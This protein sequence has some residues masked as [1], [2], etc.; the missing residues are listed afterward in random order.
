M[1]FL[2]KFANLMHIDKPFYTLILIALLGATS[3]NVHGQSLMDYIAECDMKYGSDAD[4]VNGEKYFYPYSRAEGDP[5]LFSE[6]QLS[7]IRINEKDF[8]D[9]K[10]KFDIFNQKIVL[11][12]KDLYGGTTSL[13]LRN[14]WVES[15]SMRALLFK[16]MAGPNGID[17][18]F[19]VIHEGPVSCYFGW[20]K[21]YQLNLN[22]GV[23][24]YYFTEPV[25][26]SFLVTEDGYHP[27]RSNRSFIK[28][29]DSE[30]QKAIKLFMRQAKINVKKSPDS[31]MRHLI[32]YCNSLS[33]EA[34]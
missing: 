14:E 31:E 20:K 24:S 3:L 27:F 12:Y 10:I 32:Q 26:E 2:S 13:V 29:F 28:G 23:Q 4:L 15:F 30:Q 19:Q 25:K 34:S 33:N 8:E 17:G 16:N 11:E 7:N 6:A 21:E 9:Q 22:S 1:V 18:F 5:F